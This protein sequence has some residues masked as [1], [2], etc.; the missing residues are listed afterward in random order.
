[1]LEELDEHLSMLSESLARRL[2]R[3][4]AL[5]NTAKGLFATVTG[6]TLGQLTNIT[7]A[8]AV[9]CDCHWAQGHQ[10]A[11]GG[12]GSQCPSNCTTCTNSNWC[13]GVCNYPNGH[14]VSCSGLGTCGNGYKIC[15]DCQCP[16]CSYLCTCLSTC[17]CCN[18]C[19]PKDVEAEMRRVTAALSA[20]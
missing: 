3:R 19:N 2:N 13:N 16:N 17:I 14:W 12:T 4:K 6:I 1:M 7:N 18:C 10:C 5:V 8:F 15:I 11:C 9:T 20:A